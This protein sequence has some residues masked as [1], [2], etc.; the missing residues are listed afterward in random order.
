MRLTPRLPSL[1]LILSTTGYSATQVNVYTPDD[2][3]VSGPLYS[4][5]K[6]VLHENICLLLP[7]KASNFYY[8]SDYIFTSA[9]TSPPANLSFHGENDKRGEVMHNCGATFHHLGDVRFISWI[10]TW[11]GDD[12]DT[13]VSAYGGAISGGDGD[14][15]LF[16]NNGAILFSHITYD[17]SEWGANHSNISVHGGAIHTYTAQSERV[18]FT[19]NKSVTLQ[20]ISIINEHDTNYCYKN[21]SALGGAIYTGNLQISDTTGSV[22]LNNNSIHQGV[23][24]DVE[25]VGK[26]GAAYITSSLDISNN[27]SNV[28]LDSNSILVANTAEGG[29]L[30]LKENSSSNISDNLLHIQFRANKVQAAADAK[31]NLAG[32]SLSATCEAMGGAAYIAGELLMERNSGNI[33]FESNTATADYSKVLE[34][35]RS[36][37]HDNDPAYALGGAIFLASEAHLGINHNGTENTTGMGNVTFS[38]NEV[39]TVGTSG[40][41]AQGGAVFLS[42]AAELSISDNTGNVNF[43]YNK[44]TDGGAI[45]FSEN[46]TGFIS[47]NG[48]V[49]FENNTA[50]YGAALFAASYV[51]LSLNDHVA[52]QNNTATGYGA[53]IYATSQVLINGNGSVLFSGNT[54]QEGSAIY[55]ASGSLVDI[56]HNNGDVKFTNNEL[57]TGDTTTGAIQLCSGATL[58]L[59]DNAAVVFES[60]K[61]GRGVLYGESGS[62]AHISGNE[63]VTICA[64][65][66]M[67]TSIIKTA[68][69]VYLHD[70]TNNIEL[71]N[72]SALQASGGVFTLEGSSALLS[73][74]GNSGSI[75]ATGNYATEAGGLIHAAS[76]SHILICDNADVT[77]TG[78]DSRSGAA[79]IDS[80]GSIHIRNNAGRVIFGNNRV[81]DEENGFTMCSI[82]ADN[83]QFSAAA[84]HSIEFQDSI[85][86]SPANEE[87]PA[88][89]LNADYTDSS[90]TTHKQGGDIIFTGAAADTTNA[91]SSVDAEASRHSKIDG[92]TTLHNGRL[93][94]TQQAML[95]GASLSTTEH[96][97]A[98]VV[99]SQGGY[100]NQLEVN[101][102][103]GTTLQAGDADTP[104]LLTAAPTEAETLQ[105]LI[106]NTSVCGHFGGSTLTLQSGSTYTM[107]GGILDLDGGSLNLSTGTDAITLSSTIAPT[108]IGEEYVLLLFSGVNHCEY[109]EDLLFTYN[110]YE[111]GAEHLVYSSDESAVYLRNV[112]IP[113]PATATLC[114]LALAALTTRR[115]RA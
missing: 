6:M 79:A 101:I 75:T 8:S 54:A 34:N 106:E 89:V 66:T 70:N 31:F 67:Q 47:N 10:N 64:N 52:F 112:I 48:N 45:Y 71:N 22:S 9:N 95:E 38:G 74:C 42:T 90:G 5:Y 111:Y 26:G 76:G 37:K 29:A 72:N 7:D 43:T 13:T 35:G 60:G 14:S 55:A 68:G 28:A 57:S 50:T 115:R 33:T 51:I 98:T 27:K 56:Y 87:T 110:G 102:A 17:S 84:G 59:R 41:R 25:G 4:E 113:E 81:Y 103:T 3:K 94:V 18:E 40:G 39:S 16:Q 24:T 19:G 63:T 46:S 109:D 11:G 105:Q 53:G 88:L 32:D 73:I 114:F 30:Y 44:A 80:D 104:L 15:F 99:L 2:M 107:Y 78:N 97:G 65:E 83:A 100:L 108:L 86:I 21:L 62:F 23:C 61:N 36:E 85:I 1:F 91:D 69:T 96:S 12:K 49:N 93:I 20:Y 58:K 77:I 82:R 92:A